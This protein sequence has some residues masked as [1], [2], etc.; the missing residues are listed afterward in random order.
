MTKLSITVFHEGVET[1]I[2][3]CQTCQTNVEMRERKMPL[4][5]SS[6]TS[7]VVHLNQADSIIIFV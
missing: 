3:Y 7:H 6:K 4:T 5:A 2:G 1:V